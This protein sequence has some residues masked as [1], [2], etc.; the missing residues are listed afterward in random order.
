MFKERYYEEIKKMLDMIIN[1]QSENIERAADL[2]ANSLTSGKAVYLY[3][4]G[5]HSLQL[6]GIGRAGGPM[7]LQ[8]FTF[9]L[10]LNI[11]IHPLRKPKETSEPYE[12]ASLIFKYSNLEEGDILI[13]GSVSGRNPLPVE[14]AIKAKENG[15]QTIGITSIEFSKAFP[16]RHQSGKRLFEVVD[17]VIDN[18]GVVG[19]AI[20]EVERLDVKICPTSGITGIFV[21]WLL[22]AEVIEILLAKGVKPHIYKS[23]NFD[24]GREYNERALSE[25]KKTGI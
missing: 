21:L 10:N 9:N 23:I 5:G 1:T 18:C 25:Y 13:I 24:D 7:F 3:D 19:D 8:P 15:M 6:E 4:H 17:I 22:M 12:L 2:I 11:P 16:S 20:L 14:V